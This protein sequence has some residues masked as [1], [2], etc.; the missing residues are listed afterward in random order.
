MIIGQVV[1]VHLDESYIDEKGL[2]DITRMKPIA[3]C[4]YLADYAV[5]DELFQMRR[6]A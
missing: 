5:L 1:G 3:R 2:V 4:G 6:P